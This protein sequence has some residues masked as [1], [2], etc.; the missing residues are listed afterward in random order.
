MEKG[1]SDVDL[2]ESD[3]PPAVEIVP[4]EEDAAVQTSC[5]HRT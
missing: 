5:S 4:L 3:A 2:I 1:M